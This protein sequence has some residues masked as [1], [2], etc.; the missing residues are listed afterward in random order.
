VKVEH[1]SNSRTLVIRDPRKLCAYDHEE[2]DSDMVNL[3]CFAT[4]KYEAAL[5]LYHC[6]CNGGICQC[7]KVFSAD[8]NLQSPAE[9]EESRNL[10][11]TIGERVHVKGFADA[12][13]VPP[14]EGARVSRQ[15]LRVRYDDGR[16][17]YVRKEQLQKLGR[18]PSRSSLTSGAIFEKREC[19]IRPIL[20]HRGEISCF[21]E[22][23]CAEKIDLRA[24][25]NL[26]E[27]LETVSIARQQC[28]RH[29]ERMT[30]KTQSDEEALK[31]LQRC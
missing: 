17:Y 26:M 7:K 30:Y 14:E 22:Y 9:I 24:L 20:E 11:W 27:D 5:S 25:K 31:K 8:V 12:V 15:S 4:D 23:K 1:S 29:L 28:I 18:S 10:S 19:R 2:E 6:K 21:D 13:I 3:L 16:S